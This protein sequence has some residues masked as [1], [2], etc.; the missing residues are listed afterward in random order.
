MLKQYNIWQYLNRASVHDSCI[1]TLVMECYS[2][3]RF[4]TET[5]Q[6]WY[7]VVTTLPIQK[8]NTF[9]FIWSRLLLS[10][11]CVRFSSG[12]YILVLMSA[13]FGFNAICW[14]WTAES[15]YIYQ[16]KVLDACL[17]HPLHSQNLLCR[18][19][20]FGVT[21]LMICPCC[22]IM[23]SQKDILIFFCLIF[24]CDVQVDFNF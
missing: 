16:A 5:N 4:G 17:Q 10:K 11:L 13:F 2:I 14:F 23:S 12:D 7:K 1:R 8:S 21:D 24:F 19:D 15:D 22:Y 6:K 18:N 20:L 9:F 3:Y